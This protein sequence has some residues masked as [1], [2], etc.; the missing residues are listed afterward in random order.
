MFSPSP[1]R[2]Y[3][4]LMQERHLSG[5]R[6]RGICTPARMY[7]TYVTMKAYANHQ[8]ERSHLFGCESSWLV[9]LHFRSIMDIGFIPPAWESAP[10]VRCDEP[11][12]KLI[13]MIGGWEFRLLLCAISFASLVLFLEIFFVGSC[14]YIL[15]EEA[16]LS[17]INTVE[18]IVA[19]I[20]SRIA[21]LDAYGGQCLAD[22]TGKLTVTVGAAYET[23]EEM[24][25]GDV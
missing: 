23:V 4:L 8:D 2:L 25:P 20:M 24:A 10:T 6:I 1:V 17:A 18:L 16:T 5:G 19:F 11:Q 22:D 12:Q 15:C 14:I 7:A 3:G 9:F 21:P 13:D